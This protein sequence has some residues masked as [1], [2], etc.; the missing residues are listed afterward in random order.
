MIMIDERLVKAEQKLEE[1]LDSGDE[2]AMLYWFG[3]LNG[4]KWAIEKE[5]IQTKHI[6]DLSDGALD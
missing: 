5:R 2:E 3:Y 4:V 6:E 1:A